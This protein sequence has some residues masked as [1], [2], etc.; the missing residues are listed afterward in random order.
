M[1]RAAGEVA[2]TQVLVEQARATVARS[3]SLCVECAIERGEMCFRRQA[4]R[5]VARFP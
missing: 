2:R 3:I 1:A 5:Q 4:Y